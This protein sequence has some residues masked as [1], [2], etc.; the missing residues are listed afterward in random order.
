[1]I[2]IRTRWWLLAS[3]TLSVLATMDEYHPLED[4][5]V[6]TGI[7]L[8][9]PLLT[10]LF[11]LR[12]QGQILLLTPAALMVGLADKVHREGHE[13]VLR[14]CAQRASAR[15]RRRPAGSG[16]GGCAGRWPRA[17]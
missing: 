17:P 8:F 9:A 11:S 7:H 14:G 2:A 3:W 4:W 12:L 15:A 16:R 10:V 1:M 6:I 5:I 13:P